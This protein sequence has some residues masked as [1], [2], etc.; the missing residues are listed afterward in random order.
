MQSAP[1]SNGVYKPRMRLATSNAVLFSAFVLLASGC[2]SSTSKHAA[3]IGASSKKNTTTAAA[4]SALDPKQMVLRLQDLPTGFQTAT[5]TG[6]KSI[7]DAAKNSTVSVAQYEA[8]GYLRGFEADF[9]LNG[10]LGDLMSGAAGIVSSASVYRNPAGAEQS[11]SSSVKQCSRSSSRELS[12]SRKIG[13]EAHLCVAEHTSG[14]VTAQAYAVL[15][16]RGRVKAAILV[17]GLV[18][19]TSPTEA[20]RLAQRQN[21]RMG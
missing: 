8:W 17:G 16:R 3:T 12:L 14:G 11:L 18:G 4:A 1:N 19:T 7:Q 6:Y 21:A 20:V 5:G 13:D 9:S 2:G 10:S 15:W